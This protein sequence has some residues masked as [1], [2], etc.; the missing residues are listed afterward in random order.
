MTDVCQNFSILQSR[1]FLL[2]TAR[3]ASSDGGVGGADENHHKRTMLSRLAKL[4]PSMDLIL[5]QSKLS[6]L[7]IYRSLSWQKVA[8]IVLPELSIGG[9]EGGNSA[10]S[11]DSNLM[12][13]CW[14]PNGQCVAVAQDSAILLYGVESLVTA[15]GVGAGAASGSSNATWTIDI[16]EEQKGGRQQS[17]SSGINR[18]DPPTNVLALHWVHVGKYHPTAAFPSAAEE[19]QEVSWR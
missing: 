5:V 14:S 3:G 17:S 11:S 1:K 2:P 12:S 9:S 13:Y 16:T 8:D 4:C 18:G 15:S 10:S 19:E 7:V 6:S